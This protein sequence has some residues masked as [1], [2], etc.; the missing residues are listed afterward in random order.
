MRTELTLLICMPVH[1]SMATASDVPPTLP[2]RCMSQLAYKTSS[3]SRSL[4]LTQGTSDRGTRSRRIHAKGGGF[5]PQR[6]SI[7]RRA[8]GRSGD[9]DIFVQTNSL[10]NQ[11]S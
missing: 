9:R 6:R 7:L 2:A 11:N 3:D 8:T 1:D 4:P 10:T 5:S